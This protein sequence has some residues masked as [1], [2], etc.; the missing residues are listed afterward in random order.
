MANK[1]VQQS[2]AK[3]VDARPRA[4]L[5]TTTREGLTA[6][7]RFL[8]E[9]FRRQA[10]L[11]MDSGARGKGAEATALR[12]TAS[13]L[14]LLANG[15]EKVSL[16][17]AG[18][19][20]PV[21]SRGGPKLPA[22]WCGQSH[23]HGPHDW[24]LSE[25]AG[26]ARHCT[27]HHER[28]LS[29]L[30]ELVAERAAAGK[31]EEFS[32]AE[33][34]TVPEYLR[35]GNPE[36][37]AYLRGDTNIMPGDPVAQLLNRTAREILEDAPPM[38]A[39]PTAPP[40]DPEMPGKRLTF[41]DMRATPPTEPPAHLSHSQL[42]TLG[43]CPSRYRMERLE[44]EVIARPKWANVG[45]K[46]L[47]AAAEWFEQATHNAGRNLRF[48]RDRIKTA[49]GVEK[50]WAEFFSQAVFEQSMATPAVP[51]AQWKA[52]GRGQSE[53][54]TWWLTEGEDMLRRYVESR[55]AELGQINA[56][57]VAQATDGT[58]AIELEGTLDVEGVPVKVVLD[59][60]WH[61]AGRTII[62]D[63]KS[64]AYA[65]NG[66]FQLGLYAW[67]LIKEFGFDGPIYGRFWNARKGEYSEPIDLLEAH[68][69]DEIVLRVLDAEARKSAGYY[70]PTPSYSGC[71]SCPVKH[72]CP[73]AIR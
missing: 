50:L 30:N 17:G 18:E 9:D 1:D 70:A 23:E 66:T 25:P 36:M 7:L 48:V 46:A 61:D 19:V 2:I 3:L 20:L 33:P 67:F 28:D 34:A 52:S 53:G 64:G 37:E 29:G 56:R 21:P 26:P 14:S 22:E 72:A 68:P 41:A 65:P 24:P 71:G 49:G 39:E 5:D 35:Q 40:G 31:T 4:L 51:P 57:R 11:V 32:F 58:P 73:A 38:F 63:L 8:V 60:V 12:S 27:G 16:D 47:H 10:E 6:G 42:T 15:V 13:A 43:E 54:Y 59:Q 44:P 69:W 62:D 55:I 45:G